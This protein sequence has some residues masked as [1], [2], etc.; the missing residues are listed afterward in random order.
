MKNPLLASLLF[1]S[2]LSFAGYLPSV[3]SKLPQV[4]EEVEASMM[5][6]KYDNDALADHM[7]SKLE[8][9]LMM[10]TIPGVLYQLESSGEEFFKYD[11]YVPNTEYAT[12]LLKDLNELMQT[13]SAFWKRKYEL[14]LKREVELTESEKSF[15]GRTSFPRV[16]VNQNDLKKYIEMVNKLSI[17]YESLLK[18]EKKEIEDMSRAQRKENNT[19]LEIISKTWSKQ[20]Q[21]NQDIQYN[22]S[23]TM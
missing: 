16:S 11:L 13:N 1:F 21:V 19:R 7:Q 23:K 15:L 10:D 2:S 4:R 20:M 18:I 22:W 6:E 9:T 5:L 12:K 17:V 3:E 14:S 8:G